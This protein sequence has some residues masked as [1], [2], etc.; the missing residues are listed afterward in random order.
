V[1]TASRSGGGTIRAGVYSI[2]HPD[3]HPGAKLALCT[4]GGIRM[5]WPKTL[6]AALLLTLTPLSL[7]QSGEASSGV[8]RD[9]SRPS[10]GAIT[11][12][13]LLPREKR[14]MPGD[15]TVPK[16]SG[17]TAIEGCMEL[18]GTLR[19][20]CLQKEQNA[21]GGSSGDSM[22]QAEPRIEPST[23]DRR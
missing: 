16:T 6:L 10:D 12:G 5:T 11:G 15:T 7:A 21:S 14:G 13:P 2:R 8:G 17:K 9:G 1:E 20:E 22:R 4:A 3:C 19:D 23:G 18:T